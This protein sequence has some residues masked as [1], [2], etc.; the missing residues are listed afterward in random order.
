MNDIISAR[1]SKGP[2]GLSGAYPINDK[3]SE[4]N[5]K[6]DSKIGQEQFDKSVELIRSG[7]KS[8]GDKL[9]NDIVEYK[10]VT[11]R[12]MNFCLESISTKLSA[13][14]DKVSHDLGKH[15]EYFSDYKTEQEEF[16][17]DAVNAIGSIYKAFKV[18]AFIFG[19]NMAS[20]LAI[21]IYLCTM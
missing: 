12:E 5:Q 15:I 13:N 16:N 8:V 4:L 14:I 20:I 6:M 19:L 7:I 3:F 10:S 21:V 17:K 1:I 11:I 18:V 9:E 2:D